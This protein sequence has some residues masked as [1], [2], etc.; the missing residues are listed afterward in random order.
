MLEVAILG[1][2]VGS[3]Y[4]TRYSGKFGGLLGN[5]YRTHVLAFCRH[6]S[7]ALWG[8]RSAS[9]AF[10]RYCKSVFSS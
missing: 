6:R 8:T 9:D 1:I 3:L 4:S 2:F 10:L 7:L 5:P